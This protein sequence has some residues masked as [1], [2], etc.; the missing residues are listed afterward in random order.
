MDLT[1]QPKPDHKD[2]AYA[3]IKGTIS[4][5]P[6]PFAAGIA[7]ELFSLILESPLSKRQEEWTSSLAQELVRLR[8]TVDG[9]NLEDLSSN[10]SFVTMTLQATQS[11]LRNHQQEKLDALRNAVLNSSLPSAPEDDLQLIFLNLVDTLTPW[12]L[13]MLKLFDD[14]NR[15]ADENNKPFPK[16]WYMGGVSQVIDHAYPQ[17]R[18]YGELTGKIIKDLSSYGLAEIPSGMMTVSGMLSPRS[19]DLG[20]QFLQF[21]S[22]PK[23][24]G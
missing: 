11:A 1:Q 5:I 17:L 6:I 23:P 10:E 21:I 18:Q 3:I 2:I 8:D 22:P 15:W 19:T 14:P 20:K 24:L 9:F 7:A 4:S 16:G 12:H 13:R